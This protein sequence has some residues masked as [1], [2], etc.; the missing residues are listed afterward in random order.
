M[1]PEPRAGTVGCTADLRI[2]DSR[3]PGL[4]GGTISS[5]GRVAAP[6]SDR[7]LP[8]RSA[9]ASLPGPWTN[10][11]GCYHVPTGKRGSAGPAGG[12][13]SGVAEPADVRCRVRLGVGPESDGLGPRLQS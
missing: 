2:P 11:V 9:L 4:A 7:L 1:N 10:S 12:E 5:G 13:S 8:S 6:A 3:T